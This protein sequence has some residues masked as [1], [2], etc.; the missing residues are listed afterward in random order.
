[1][2]K[3]MVLGSQHC[4]LPDLADCDMCNLYMDSCDGR[5][6][7]DEVSLEDVAVGLVGE[8]TN[9]KL[10]DKQFAQLRATYNTPLCHSCGHF[11]PAPLIILNR[12]NSMSIRRHDEF[13]SVD[14]DIL[15][16]PVC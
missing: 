16:C 8:A 4:R 3:D 14:V 5:M 1:M 13:E 7:E 11:G 6:E 2:A 12:S 10:E 9:T 15:M